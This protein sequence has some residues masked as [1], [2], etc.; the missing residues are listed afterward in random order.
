MADVNLGELIKSHEV[1]GKI[2]TVTAVQP[3]SRFGV[4][5]QEED[6]TVLAFSEKPQSSSWINAGFFVFKNEVFDYL[7]DTS[8]L[9][10]APMHNLVNARQLNSYRHQGFWQ[11]MDTFREAQ[12]LNGMW[13]RGEAPWKT[14]E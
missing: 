9:E 6:G 7:D 3:I 14:W 12:M 10:D 8:M 2:A 4:L 5:E 13:A 11:P 1:S